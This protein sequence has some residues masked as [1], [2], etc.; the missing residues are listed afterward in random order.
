MADR[1]YGYNAAGAQQTYAT[2]ADAIT[3][4]DPGDNLQNYYPDNAKGIIWKERPG[5]LAATPYSMEGMVDD[6]VFYATGAFYDCTGDLAGVPAITI[7]KIRLVQYTGYY[8]FDFA[9]ISNGTVTINRCLS[10]HAAIAG[11]TGVTIKNCVAGYGRYGYVPWNGTNLY[12]CTAVLCEQYGIN[13]VADACTIKNCLSAYN[14]LADYQ[15]VQNATG[16]FNACTDGTC[17]DGNWGTGSDNLPSRTRAQIGFKADDSNDTFPLE[18]RLDPESSLVGAGEATGGVTVDFDGETRADPPSVGAS[19]GIEFMSSTA[20]TFG[21]ITALTNNG[22][23]TLT[24]SFDDATVGTIS[25][26]EVSIHT[27]SMSSGDLTAQTYMCKSVYDDGSDSFD[28]IIGTTAGGAALLTSGTTYYVA[29]RAVS[30]AGAMDTGDTNLSA[31]ATGG[32]NAGAPGV[33]IDDTTPVQLA[34][35]ATTIYEVPAGKRATVLSLLLCNTDSSA[36]TVTLYKQISGDAVADDNAFLKSYSLDAA[37]GI[38]HTWMDKP[39]LTLTAGT[40]I[41][42]IASVAD[43]VTAMV[44]VVEVTP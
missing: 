28:C 42:G 32:V 6:V 11:E 24:A 43:K 4:S 37:G 35:S 30:T 2:Q 22:N 26:Y 34:D 20:P 40:K 1:K 23:G 33:E 44:G 3:A 19:E 12:N 21:G 10:L 17:A 13:A 29:V 25:H 8:S 36:R 9:G 38:G 15:T 7:Q 39:G 18:W 31:T 41:V 27:S 16:T 14:T 5:S